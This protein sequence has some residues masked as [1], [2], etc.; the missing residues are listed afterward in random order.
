MVNLLLVLLLTSGSLAYAMREDDNDVEQR[1]EDLTE[2]GLVGSFA[3]MKNNKSKEEREEARRKK[4]GRKEMKA[5]RKLN[6]YRTNR[7][8]RS[9]PLGERVS[10][11]RDK[12]I[13]DENR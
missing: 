6:E 13:E 7:Y 2:G 8:K 3:I 5:K 1:F 9:E 4:R 10:W 11:H 12:P